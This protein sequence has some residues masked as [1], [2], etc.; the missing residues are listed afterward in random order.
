MSL[1]LSNALELPSLGLHRKCLKRRHFCFRFGWLVCRLLSDGLHLNLQL[2]L[3]LTLFANPYILGNFHLVSSHPDDILQF[4]EPLPKLY[5]RNR[6]DNFDLQLRVEEVA[7]KLNKIAL[8]VADFWVRSDF[9]IRYFLCFSFD[10]RFLLCLATSRLF[11]EGFRLFRLFWLLFL[12]LV[13]H[14][15]NLAS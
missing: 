12:L 5:A 14:H 6:I 15:N 11:F 8:V 9:N 13:V 10:Y 7:D 1:E 4:V 2:S 3:G